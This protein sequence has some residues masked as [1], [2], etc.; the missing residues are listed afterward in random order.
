MA[1]KK[2]AM[3]KERTKRR[4]TTTMTSLIANAQGE[5]MK[6]ARSAYIAVLETYAAE[7]CQ[8]NAYALPFHYPFCNCFFILSAYILYASLS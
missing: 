1:K 6:M 2:E 5:H 3:P 4:R 8:P 7:C